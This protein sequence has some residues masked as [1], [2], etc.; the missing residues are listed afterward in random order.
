MSRLLV[1]GFKSFSSRSE[2]ELGPGIT[3]VVGPNGSGKSNLV[4]AI[5]LVLGETQA[6]E[7]RGQ[8]LDQMIF[9]GGAK[10]APQGMAEV[11]L[12]LDNDD[13]R[14]PVEDVEVAIT[15]RV[16]RDGQ[17]EFRRN[18]QR[19]R[20]R[21]L[22]RL[23]DATGLAQAG[24]AVIAQNDI[25]S[26]IRATPGQRRHLVEE[27]AGIRGAQALLDDA[28]SRISSLS[29]W[30][31]G[32]SG[33]LAELLPRIEQLRQ[34][35]AA[36]E[37]A[38][39]LRAQLE[40]LRGSL[41]RGNWLNA[42][43]ELRRLE[44]QEESGQRRVEQAQAR[45]R[46]FAPRYQ[47]ER[48]RLL[49]AQEGRMEADL[50]SQRLGLLQDQAQAQVDRFEER[51]LQAA[52][53]RAQAVLLLAEVAE[54]LDD[55]GA[56]P[57]P[58]LAGPAPIDQIRAEVQ[59]GEGGLAELAQATEGAR[60]GLD[61]AVAELRQAESALDQC[62]SRRRELEAEAVGTRAWAERAQVALSEQR[63]LQEEEEE[64][65][66]QA[67]SQAAQ[68]KEEASRAAV[69]LERVRRAEQ[70]AGQSRRRAE[71]ELSQATVGLREAEA[72]RAGVLA[73]L[74]ATTDSSPIAAAAAEG[75][76]RLRALADGLQAAQAEDA[77]AV[78]AGLG[79]FTRA[80]VGDEPTA[81]QALALAGPAQEVV[82]W[83]G[84]DEPAVANPP[85]GCRPLAT[86]VIGEAAILAVVGR[87]CRLVCLAEDRLAAAR[88][89]ARLPDGRAVLPDGTV[90]GNGLEIT[91]S[92][93]PGGLRLAEAARSAERTVELQH[94]HL[95][96]A[97]QV[98]ERARAQHEAAQEELERQRLALTAAQGRAQSAESEQQRARTRRDQARARLSQL[99]QE[100]E[101]RLREA[102]PRT[103][104]LA[105]LQPELERLEAQAG[106]GTQRCEW[107][108]AAA[109]EAEQ[110]HRSRRDALE[111]RRAELGALEARLAA[112]QRLQLESARRR[113]SLGRR[114]E[115]AQQRLR[116][117]A[118]AALEALL[119]LRAAKEALEEAR[120]QARTASEERGQAG[121]QADPLQA[122]GQL[123]R[124]QAEMEAALGA[125]REQ[126]ARQADERQAQLGRVEQLRG[127]YQVSVGGEAAPADEQ[128]PDPARAA[129]ELARC[130]RR[131]RALGPINELAPGQLVELLERTSGLR[132]AH[133]DCQGARSELEAA[134]ASLQ[135]RSQGR[136]DATF[137]QVAREFSKAWSDLFGGGRAELL[138]VAAEE[139][140]IAGVEMRV[141]PPGKRPIA[142]ALLSGGERALTAL[143]LVL[144]LQQVSP[145]PFYVFDEVDAALDEANIVHF[146][147]LLQR[148]S[149]QTQFLVVTHSLITMS[150]AD[151]LYGV[152]Q[153]GDGS[154]RILSVRLS[155]QGE[156]V[157]VTP[158]LEPVAALGG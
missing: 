114:R 32:S 85:E 158:E 6:R 27:A 81:R 7:L 105:R 104:E 9:A 25:E 34:E 4:D 119:Q 68:A 64:A 101:R 137:S 113:Q 12:V 126:L 48:Q 88:W 146:A 145:S 56:A 45:V 3:A 36:A 134:L 89:L 125:A 5:R 152:T 41:E 135:A 53:G 40:R 1:Q 57:E 31:D 96:Q 66:R 93:D 33:R 102:Q 29:Q 107:A 63:R 19:V 61:Q 143:A 92:A 54:D 151:F 87:I 123:E 55:L 75:R 130:E 156:P 78:E 132:A 155:A 13:G 148:R 112:E 142:M 16:F 147:D 91:P 46:E 120:Q 47:S 86:A 106:A 69:A 74:G 62:R 72:R 39:G 111:M 51:A 115:Q 149:R 11:T 127:E 136:F 30:F 77:L 8:R 18:G 65:H 44:R 90:V 154:S 141:Q 79:I 70:A 103:L 144:A 94:R 71:Q 128:L 20:L 73:Q 60:A 76:T 38:A 49:R 22:G 67:V 110:A 118:A 157:E 14:L 98:A 122:L 35:A 59:H 133:E 109:E 95:G 52:E 80:L 139:G 37:E 84:A 83:T 116:S 129:A 50:Q 100:E 140:G 138:E 42:L 43:A 24:Y 17:S 150:R 21:D 108:R 99:E 2:L 10:R 15:R 124:T 58:A 131:L 117:A 82:C 153:D 97:Q 121:A 26:I 23:L 28:R